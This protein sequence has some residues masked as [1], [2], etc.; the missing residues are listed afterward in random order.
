MSY[1]QIVASDGEVARL[2]ESGKIS[3]GCVFMFDRVRYEV[4]PFAI[5]S[6]CGDRLADLSSSY[7]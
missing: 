6:S 4:V 3:F 7:A 1:I 5:F 2:D